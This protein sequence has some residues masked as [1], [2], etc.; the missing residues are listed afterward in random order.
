MRRLTALG[1]SLHEDSGVTGMVGYV[2]A[3]V[4]GRVPAAES[5]PNLPKNCTEIE[6]ERLFLFLS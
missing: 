1:V 2:C 3:C 6:I 5:V 4:P